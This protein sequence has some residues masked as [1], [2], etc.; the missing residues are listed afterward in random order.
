MSAFE[1]GLD[2]STLLESKLCS[3]ILEAQEVEHFYRFP[4]FH[5][6]DTK[7]TV[8]FKNSFMELLHDEEAYEQNFGED[9]PFDT[10]DQKNL[11]KS[12]KL[13]TNRIAN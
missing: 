1:R 12:T 4:G 5:S 7:A 2:I 13:S 8:N 9:Y 6:N 10:E 11:I 3:Y